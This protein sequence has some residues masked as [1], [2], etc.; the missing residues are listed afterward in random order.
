MEH[1]QRGTG[2]AILD[3][4]TPG[5]G[6]L[7]VPDRVGTGYASQHRLLLGT[8]LSLWISGN[9]LLSLPGKAD[10]PPPVSAKGPRIVR[11][12]IHGALGGNT[13]SATDREAPSGADID[14]YLAS[15]R[16]H[17]HST[18]EQ[19]RMA[20]ERVIVHIPYTCGPS[21]GLPPMGS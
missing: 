16:H 4:I 6:T 10:T 12:P 19:V 5:Y 2:D 20:V 9:I 3:Q 7:S 1:A 13:Q 17:Y 14:G 15:Y 21:G 18:P 8:G 11:Q